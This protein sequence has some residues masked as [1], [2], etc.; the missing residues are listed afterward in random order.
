MALLDPLRAVAARA[1]GRPASLVGRTSLSPRVTRIRL[2]GPALRELPW[3][4]GDKVKLAIPGG[5]RS[6]T[7]FA[8]DRASG[9]FDVVV[10]LHGNGPASQWA[11]E[12]PLGSEVRVVGPARSLTPV[13]GAVEWALFYGDETAL[14]LARALVDAHDGPV[15]GAVEVDAADL[16][17]VQELALPM[18]A[19]VRAEEHGATLLDHAR[20]LQLPLG[21]GAVFLSGHAATAVALRRVFLE[22]GV[23]RSRIRTKA[24]WSDQGHAHRKRLERTALLR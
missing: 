6:Y 20:S 21:P 23:P 7:P 16:P 13:E 4:P 22:R 5:L 8:V 11:A 3:Q 2:A 24:Y 18:E 17:S 10:H 1:V 19:R 15:G 9:R 12:A 14:G